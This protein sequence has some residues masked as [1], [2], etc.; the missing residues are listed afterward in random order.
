MDKPQRNRI[1]GIIKYHNRQYLESIKNVKHRSIFEHKL[2]N[3]THKIRSLTRKEYGSENSIHELSRIGR[4]IAACME[5]MKQRKVAIFDFIEYK[6]VLNEYLVKYLEFKRINKYNGQ[7]AS[8]GETLFVLYLD[9][10]ITATIDKV[11]RE[12]QAKPAF[13]INPRTGSILEIDVL[14]EGFKLAFEFQG[15]HHYTN[16]GVQ[17]KDQ[18]KLNECLS[19]GIIL[20]PVNISQ[21]NSRTLQ[22]LITNSIKDFLGIHDIFTPNR[23]TFSPYKNIKSKQFISFCKIT[24]RLYTSS[25]IFDASTNWLDSEA[26]KYI[27]NSQVRS[28]ISSTMLAP[29]QILP[30]GDFDIAI[31]YQGLKHVAL[32]RKKYRKSESSR[33]I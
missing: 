12:L 10:F 5:D 8:Y 20:I 2:T 25:V 19:R 28:P 13:L 9:L 22:N 6:N 3:L 4:L 30:S 29:R 27:S 1:T 7:C 16:S 23:D 24:E 26:V 14:F 17:N 33:L 15:E 32:F 31:L 21:L 11:E 18:F